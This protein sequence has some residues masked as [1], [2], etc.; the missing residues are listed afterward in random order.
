MFLTSHVV[1]DMESLV[2]DVLFLQRGGL[3]RQWP[4]AEFRRGFRCFGFSCDGKTDDGETPLRAD[5]V[6][7]S[8]DLHALKPCLYSFAEPEQLAA[9]LATHWP[10]VR[11]GDE[12]PLTLEDAFIG[13][14]GKY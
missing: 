9:H 10:Q 8:V 1:Q 4:L 6:I 7:E 5:G 13:L 3:L 11:L 14:T 12:Q 2:D